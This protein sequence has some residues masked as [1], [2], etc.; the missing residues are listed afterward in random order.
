MGPATA[1]ATGSSVTVV[2]SHLN[3]PRALSADGGKL[4]LAEAGRGGTNCLDPTTCVGLTGSIDQVGTNGVTR[5]VTGLITERGIVAPT[6]EALAK[7]FKER[8]AAAE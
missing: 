8:A 2:A 6:R 1:S 4:Y 7:A 3:N 5:L